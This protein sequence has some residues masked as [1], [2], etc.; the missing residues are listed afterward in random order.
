MVGRKTSN[1]SKDDRYIYIYGKRAVA[2]VD[3][4]EC[5][6]ERKTRGRRRGRKERVSEGDTG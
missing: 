6:R 5:D 4:H 2:R 1:E 3:R